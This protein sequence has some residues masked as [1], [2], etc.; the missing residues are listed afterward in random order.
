MSALHATVCTEA[1]KNHH[2]DKSVKLL[3]PFR[4]LAD[5]F[6][7]MRTGANQRFDN[8]CCRI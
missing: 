7:E 2:A 5:W 8:P 4:W 3:G 1:D 6:A